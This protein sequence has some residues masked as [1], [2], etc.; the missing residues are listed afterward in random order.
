MTVSLLGDGMYFVAIAWQVY[1]LS[2]APTALAIVGVAW[3]A[4]TVLFLLVG[5][6]ISDHRSDA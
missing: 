1:A 2:S 3:T 5:G 4:P 6:A